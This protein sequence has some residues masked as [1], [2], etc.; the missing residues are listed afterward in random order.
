MIACSNIM[1]CLKPKGKC[2]YG[3]C[4]YVPYPM[5]TKALVVKRTRSMEAGMLQRV[6]KYFF[7]QKER[8]LTGRPLLSRSTRR[9]YLG[10]EILFQR[11]YKLKKAKALA[12]CRRKMPTQY[13]VVQCHRWPQVKGDSFERFVVPQGLISLA[14]LNRIS[15]TRVVDTSN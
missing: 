11:F 1:G 10:H 2:K 4:R 5:S 8:K 3:W 12:S 7:A 14:K 6:V 9:N 15:I 13:W